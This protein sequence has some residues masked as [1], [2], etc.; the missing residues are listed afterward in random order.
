MRSRSS[1]RSVSSTWYNPTGAATTRAPVASWV[2]NHLFPSTKG[3]PKRPL[4]IG[5]LAGCNLFRYTGRMRLTIAILAFAGLAVAARAQDPGSSGSNVP[6]A[7]K[8]GG[9]QKM[10]LL[11]RT[12]VNPGSWKAADIE[13]EQD[14]NRPYVYVC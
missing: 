10:K 11:S 3:W 2:T 8:R 7:Q 12:E 5:R 6:D 14:K 1:R 4:G 13:I 9:S